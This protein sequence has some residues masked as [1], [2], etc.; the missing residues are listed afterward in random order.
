MEPKGRE[1]ART[2]LEEA[3]ALW[4]ALG[5]G[6]PVLPGDE[7]V[8][9]QGGRYTAVGVA[10]GRPDS[11]VAEAHGE[12]GLVLLKPHRLSRAEPEADSWEALE[13]DARS[14]GEWEYWGCAG[15]PCTMCPAKERGMTPDERYGATDCGRAMVL[16]VLARAM[17]LAAEG[18]G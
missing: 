1:G 18:R 7:L 17:A 12:P 3:V 15:S 4:P 5:D 10:P 8:G 16:D 9:P 11:V 6:S 13:A 14:G 2:P